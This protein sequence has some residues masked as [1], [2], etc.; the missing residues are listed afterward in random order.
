[1]GHT[2][3]PE[4][5]CGRL[6]TIRLA[7]EA[8][9]VYDRHI[10]WIGETPDERIL[11]LRGIQKPPPLRTGSRNNY[12]NFR[13]KP[14]TKMANALEPTID[15]LKWTICAAREVFGLI[16]PYNLLQP[17]GGRFS[18]PDRCWIERLGRCFANNERP[19]QSQGRGRRSIDF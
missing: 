15:D 5:P 11:A 10:D 13:A 6:E 2:W 3:T 18:R 1:M 4:G 8:Q 7:G 9:F 19:R 12:Q 14:G 16:W 17:D